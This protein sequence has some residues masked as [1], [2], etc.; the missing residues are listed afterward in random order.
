MT[1]IAVASSVPVDHEQRQS[2]VILNQTLS[3]LVSRGKIHLPVLRI[4]RWPAM[5]HIVAELPKYLKWGQIR[6]AVNSSHGQCQ[7]AGKTK[8][9][10]ARQ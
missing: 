4:G 6:A 10:Y 2:L 8:Y 3:T 7:V 1:R 5:T 9:D